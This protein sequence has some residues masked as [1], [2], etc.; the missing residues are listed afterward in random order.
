MPDPPDEKTTFERMPGEPPVAWHAFTVYR[1]LGPTRTFEQTR[2]ILGK[3]EGYL[4]TVEQ[5]SMKWQWARRCMKWDALLDA[6]TREAAFQRLPM[7]EARRQESLERNMEAAAVVRSRLLEMTSYPLVRRHESEDGREVTIEPAK[8]NW[9]AVIQGFK[10]VA[11]M[12]A[13]T[14]AEGLLEADDED[15]D[16]ET[17]TPE[18]LKAFIGKH[19]RRKP[20]SNLGNLGT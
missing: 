6:K 10:M 12:E 1:D 7:W 15:F 11:E 17:A 13:A 5:F 2:K 4:T 14:I 8:W 16:P 20:G 9:T 3:S 19:R 18:E